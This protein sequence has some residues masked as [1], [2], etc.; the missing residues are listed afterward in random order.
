MDK[1]I[2][3][4]IPC[5]SLPYLCNDDPSGLSDEEIT[6]VDNYCQRNKVAVVCPI[7][8]S[9]EGELL[10]YFTS[11]PAIGH[12]ACDVIDCIVLCNN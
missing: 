12:L 9:V 5:W 10:P 7:N 1:K 2:I 3:E 4:K 6:L 11:S 8:D